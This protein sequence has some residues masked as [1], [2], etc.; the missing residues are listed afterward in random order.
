MGRSIA[1]LMMQ[2]Y[3]SRV[4][5]GVV[6]SRPLLSLCFHTDWGLANVGVGGFLTGG[7]NLAR[8]SIR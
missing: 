4:H 8:S 7:T 2:D 1:S 5:D 6:Y 3:L